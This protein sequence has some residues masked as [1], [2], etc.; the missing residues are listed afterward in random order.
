MKNARNG[1]KVP[2]VGQSLEKLES[3]VKEMGF[4]RFRAK[5][6]F[7]WI[8]QHHIEKIDEMSNVP[9]ALLAKL[10]E[11]HILHPLSLKLHTP[12]ELEPTEKFLF[13]VQSGEKI[14]TV[15]M[16]DGKRNTICLSTQIG[17]AVDCDFCATAKMGFQK[18]LSAGEIVDQFIQVQR[19]TTLPIT[20]IVFMGMGEPFLNYKNVILAADLLNHSE[21]IGMG[22]RRITISTAGIVPKIKQFAEEKHKYKLAISLN[23]PNESRRETIMPITKTHRLNDLMEAANLYY[24]SSGRFPTFEYVLLAGINDSLKDANQLIQLIGRQPCKLNVIPYNEIGG[25]YERPSED[26]IKSFLS[27]LK[28]VPFQVTVRWSRGTDIKAG[29]GQLAVD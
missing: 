17:W 23:A 29:C 9:K 27:Q 13:T 16:K 11:T 7:Q 10:S 14:E 3:I 26:E 5:Q 25:K 28:N 12:S 15:I 1:E 19:R 18:N 6:V 21:G 8:Y 4:P 2:V 20:N 24:E 22:A